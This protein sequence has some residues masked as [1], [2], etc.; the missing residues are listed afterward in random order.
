LEKYVRQHGVKVVPN[1]Q[2]EIKI[3]QQELGL[4]QYKF[5]F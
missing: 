1:L 3:M 2:K 5:D 4:S